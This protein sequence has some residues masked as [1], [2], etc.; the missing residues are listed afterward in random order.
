MKSPKKDNF[1]LPHIDDTLD[2]LHGTQFF[3]TMDLMSG[4]WQVE[5]AREAREKNAFTTCNGLF[6][7]LVLPFSLT[8]APATF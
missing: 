3:L 1:R 8:N 5:L 6:Q 4:Y 2:A 7:F